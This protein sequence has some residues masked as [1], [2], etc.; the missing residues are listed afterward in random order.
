MLE[1]W[2][3]ST[4]SSKLSNSIVTKTLLMR[5]TSYLYLKMGQPKFGS[6]ESLFGYIETRVESISSLMFFYFEKYFIYLQGHIYNHTHSGIWTRVS[7]LIQARSPGCLPI[8]HFL[9][10]CISSLML[11]KQHIL[12][13]LVL[14]QLYSGASRDKKPLFQGKCM[15][16][17]LPLVTL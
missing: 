11:W 10:G 14:Q 6:G 16:A 1:W 4:L 17:Q 2:Y 7:T 13:S 9:V 8:D 12:Y 5:G 15:L 3:S